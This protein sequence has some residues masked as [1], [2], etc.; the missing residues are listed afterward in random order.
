MANLARKKK[1]QEEEIEELRSTIA[2]LEVQV[3]NQDTSP[4]NTSDTPSDDLV[5]MPTAPTPTLRP[6]KFVIQ[7]SIGTSTA[8]PDEVQVHTEGNSQAEFYT[9]VKPSDRVMWIIQMRARTSESKLMCTVLAGHVRFH[10]S[11]NF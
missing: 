3:R 6:T 2:R 7:P 8:Q 1:E 10:E 11:G 9:L 4:S 5:P